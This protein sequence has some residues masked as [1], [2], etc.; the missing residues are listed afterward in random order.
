MPGYDIDMVNTEMFNEFFCNVCHLLLKDAI[1]LVHGERICLS[2]YDEN[3]HK[4][5]D[6][7]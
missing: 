6:H 3:K 1:Q 5:T 2:C 4:T 7:E